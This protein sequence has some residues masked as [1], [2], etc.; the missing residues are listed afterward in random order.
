L[1]LRQ[2]CKRRLLAPFLLMAPGK[3]RN[4]RRAAFLVGGT[5]IAE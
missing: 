5:V 1:A 4:A 2:H 3:W